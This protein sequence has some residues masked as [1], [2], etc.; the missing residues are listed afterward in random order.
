M[1]QQ[2]NVANKC[3]N[4]KMLQQKML[5]INVANKC[6]NKKCC[7]K[8]IATKNVKKKMLQPK[9]KNEENCYLKL[10]KI[11]LIKVPEEDFLHAWICGGGDAVAI[12]IKVLMEYMED[13][14][15]KLKN[16]D[17]GYGWMYES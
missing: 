14:E 16:C 5:Q 3:C 13:F 12:D 17:K 8:K 4:K 11:C 6:C 15:V 10:D 2:K 7:K 9:K 1:L